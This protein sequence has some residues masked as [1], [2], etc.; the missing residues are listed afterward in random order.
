MSDDRRQ[1]TEGRDRIGEIE[2]RVDGALAQLHAF[3][4]IVSLMLVV[5]FIAQIGLAISGVVIRI[6][7]GD[8]NTRLISDNAQRITDIQGSRLKACQETNARHRATIAKLKALD[9]QAAK[10]APTELV[11]LFNS[12]GLSISAQQKAALAAFEVSQ[13]PQS[14]ASTAALI[15]EI[16]PLRDGQHGRESCRQVVA[17]GK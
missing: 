9:A 10:R 17:A 14:V 5:L 12:I 16:T 8:T 11:E 7:Q 4:R 15:N 3:I 2:T 6:E 13:V 1:D